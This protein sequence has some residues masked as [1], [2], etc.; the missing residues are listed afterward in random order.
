MVGQVCLVGGQRPLHLAAKQGSGPLCKLLLGAGADLALTDL[1]GDT[2][3]QMALLYSK[4][5][6]LLDTTS[7]CVHQEVPRVLSS[8]LLCCFLIEFARVVLS[9]LL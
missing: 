4:P 9:V 8:Q 7:G 1:N 3:W 6:P 5:H 2:A